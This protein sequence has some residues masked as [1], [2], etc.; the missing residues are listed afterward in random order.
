MK[1]KKE[2]QIKEA[3]LGTPEDSG[4]RTLPSGLKSYGVPNLLAPSQ[5]DPEAAT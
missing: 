1:S 3:L 2:H 4:G 5:M